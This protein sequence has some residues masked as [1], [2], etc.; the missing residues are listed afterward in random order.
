MIDQTTDRLYDTK[1]SRKTMDDAWHI[2]Q[3]ELLTG[4]QIIEISYLS[5]PESQRPVW[6]ASAMHPEHPDAEFVEGEGPTPV[7]ALL[8]LARRLHER[9]HRVGR[10][11]REYLPPRL[12]RAAGRDSPFRSH[13]MGTPSAVGS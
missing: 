3:D 10:P 7:K 1:R 4:W 2:A 8:A 12:P 9:R 13:D 5:G 11:P 6:Y